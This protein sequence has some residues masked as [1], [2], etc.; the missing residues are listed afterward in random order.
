M[1]AIAAPCRGFPTDFPVVGS[2]VERRAASERRGF[3]TDFPVVGC[4]R[5]RW[6]DAIEPWLPYRFPCGRLS[7]CSLVS[8]YA[9]VASLPI[10]LW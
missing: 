3:P 9:A 6:H 8:S 2:A 4:D 10:S 1:P 5:R 7:R